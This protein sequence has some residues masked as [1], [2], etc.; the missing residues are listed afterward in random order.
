MVAV[1][2]AKEEGT[3]GMPISNFGLSFGFFFAS[4]FFSSHLLWFGGG[5]EGCYTA[6]ILVLYLHFIYI[7]GELS[8]AAR[9]KCR[10]LESLN[11]FAK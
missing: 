5:G 8:F 11:V 2:Y 7:S 6:A 4:I 3:R 9:P 1:G 10:I